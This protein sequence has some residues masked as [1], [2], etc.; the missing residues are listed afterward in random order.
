[1]KQIYF[2]YEAAS[3]FLRHI[4]EKICEKI[5]FCLFVD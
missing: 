2:T 4:G 5:N 1:M 3:L